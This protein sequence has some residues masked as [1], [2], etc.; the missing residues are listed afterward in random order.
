VVSED[1]SA[2]FV[3]D[4]KQGLVAR[5]RPVETGAR[6]GGR[7]EVVR[8]LDPGERVIVGG[9]SLLEDGDHVTE[10]KDEPK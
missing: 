2:V 8:G 6:G 5:R 4:R 1:G 7:I 9:A 3:V 10:V